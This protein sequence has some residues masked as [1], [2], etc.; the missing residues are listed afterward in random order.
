LLNIVYK[1]NIYNCKE[2]EKLAS[3]F[4]IYDFFFVINSKRLETTSFK[5][6]QYIRK[7]PKINKGM[8]LCLK[9]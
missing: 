9:K 6:Q 5:K 8:D 7:Q 4:L 3:A 2:A 1:G